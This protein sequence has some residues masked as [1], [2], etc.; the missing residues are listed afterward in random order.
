MKFSDGLPPAAR[1]IYLEHMRAN[2]KK[3]GEATK[4]KHGI[5]H[6]RNINP[7]AKKKEV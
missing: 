7:F 6:Y 2:G 3:G 1:K 4:K 5:E